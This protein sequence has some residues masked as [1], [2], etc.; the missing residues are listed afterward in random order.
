TFTGMT[1]WKEEL[2]TQA[3]LSCQRV[4]VT[5]VYELGFRRSRERFFFFFFYDYTCEVILLIASSKL[6]ITSNRYYKKRVNHS[7]EIGLLISLRLR[8]F[9]S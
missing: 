6:F 5:S 7:N 9:F 2:V 8:L 3:A 4:S 1:V